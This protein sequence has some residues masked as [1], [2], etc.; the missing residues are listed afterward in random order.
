MRTPLSSFVGISILPRMRRSALFLDALWKAGR[1]F[2]APSPLWQDYQLALQLAGVVE[3]FG[4]VQRG[5]KPLLASGTL[6]IANGPALCSPL[7]GV[8]LAESK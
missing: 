3:L 6:I 5:P 7:N 4:L 8:G 1:P 2:I